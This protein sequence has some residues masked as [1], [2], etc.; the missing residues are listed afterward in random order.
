M[1]GRKVIPAASIAEEPR[2]RLGGSHT[3]TEEDTELDG[4]DGQLTA[5]GRSGIDI[6]RSTHFWKLCPPPQA[7]TFQMCRK[8]LRHSK[9]AVQAQSKDPCP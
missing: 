7:A 1:Q 9:A 3:E 6:Y 4:T 2:T 8:V 5:G